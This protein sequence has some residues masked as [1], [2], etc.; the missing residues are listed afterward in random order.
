MQQQTHPTRLLRCRPVPLTLFAQLTAATV[1]DLGGEEHSQR[2]ISFAALFGRMQALPS[3]AAQPAI[4]LR[5]KVA[6]GETPGFPGQ[7]T[8]GKA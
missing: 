5:S 2:T 1:S 8:L 7:A 4:R 3:R 6:P